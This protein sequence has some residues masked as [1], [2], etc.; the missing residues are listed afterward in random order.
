[1]SKKIIFFDVD[2]TLVDVRPSREYIPE[3]T[4]RAIKETRKKGNLC[5]LCTGRSKAEIYPYILDVGFDGIIGAG[6]GFVEIGDKI[7]YH[8][9]V[10]LNEVTHVVDFFDT[11]GFDY[12]V[13]S[14]GGLYASKNLIPRLERIIYGDLE[15]DPNAVKLKEESPSHFI[16]AL[17]EGYDLHRT[18]VNKICFLEHDAFPFETVYKEFEKEFNVIHCTVPMFGDNSGELSVPGVNKQY[19]IDKLIKHLN[20]P[21]EN[22]YAYG[23]GLNDIDMLEYCQY[24][25]AVGNA[26]EALKE[27]ADEVTEDIAEDGIYNSM[28]KHGLI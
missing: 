27:I 23:D 9:Q 19:A 17:K 6:G 26:K 4:I 18:D 28:K 22:T 14:N 10:S 7:L 12:Y 2:G 20:I 1:M 3:S 11:N 25:I 8:K 16:E 15:N 21:K 5:F 24:G 13:E